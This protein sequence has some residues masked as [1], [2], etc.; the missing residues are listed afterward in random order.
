[1]STG[2]E[3]SSQGHPYCERLLFDGLRWTDERCQIVRELVVMRSAIQER[4]IEVS[5][6]AQ[7]K[8]RGNFVLLNDLAR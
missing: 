3:R 7:L 5:E 6:S 4:P 8:K 2:S 1:M